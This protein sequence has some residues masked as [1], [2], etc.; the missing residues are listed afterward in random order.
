MTIVRSEPGVLYT[1]EPLLHDL[2]PEWKPLLSNVSFME[3]VGIENLRIEFPESEYAGHHLEEG[4]NGLYLTDLSH[5]WVRDV[6]IHNSDTAL[7]TTNSRNISI[8]GFITTGREGHHSVWLGDVYGVLTTNFRFE[9]DS[10]HN[11]SFNTKSR[12]SVFSGGTIP[13]A[14][15]DQH[16]G[17]N[18]QNLFDDIGGG[19]SRSSI[20][21]GGS[22][23]WNPGAGLYNTFWNIRLSGRLSDGYIGSCSDAAEARIVG[24]TAGSSELVLRYGPATYVEGLNRPGIAVRS[25]Y[26]YQLAR[27]LAAQQTAAE[28]EGH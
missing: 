15:L 21:C 5:S 25:L 10:R 19:A 1:K 8:D 20:T 27:R 3:Y 14:H 18:H 24:L 4:F 7:L 12:L 23:Y 17:L 26:R 6:S 16:G 22:P 28:N 13:R 11:P 9:A 2:R